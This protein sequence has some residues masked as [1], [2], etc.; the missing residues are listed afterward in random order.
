MKEIKFRQFVN[1]KFH[2]WGFINDGFIG[3]ASNTGDGG[4]LDSQQFTSL[5][6]KNGKEVYEGD[7]LDIHDVTIG[8]EDVVRGE[9][10]WCEDY[11][12]YSVQWLPKQSGADSMRLIK[13]SLKTNG[14]VPKS[15]L[16]DRRWPF[17]EVVG[18]IYENP[19]LFQ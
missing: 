17:I 3:P 12:E 16:G 18:N 10:Y 4:I 1:G 15:N 13:K 2:Y 9:V 6:D 5:E 11:L 8:T 7:I 19:N 14:N